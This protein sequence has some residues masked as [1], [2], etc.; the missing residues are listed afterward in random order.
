MAKWGTPF[1]Q[2]IIMLWHQTE[3]LS[4]ASCHKRAVKKVVE[5]MVNME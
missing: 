2:M 5:Y 4:L 3:F 1:V